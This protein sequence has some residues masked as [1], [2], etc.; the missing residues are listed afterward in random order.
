M[1]R[2]LRQVQRAIDRIESALFEDIALADLAAGVGASPWHF[3]RVFAAMTGMSPA[4]YARRRRL[5]ELCRRLSETEQP[6]VQIALEGGF[7]SQT[8]FTRAFSR[9]VGLSPAR[10]RNALREEPKDKPRIDRATLALAH[11]FPRIDAVALTA[12]N[13]HDVMEPKI[14]HRPA[15]HVVGLTGQY[16]P[17]TSTRIPE[18]WSRF[19][20]RLGEIGKRVDGRSYGVC[21]ENTSGDAEEGCFTYVVGVEV[22]QIERVP[23][24]MI[25]LTVPAHTYAVFTHRGHVSG[26]SDTFKRA[27]GQWLPA[28]QF[29]HAAAPD[30]EQYDERFNPT[31]ASGEIDLYLPVVKE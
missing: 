10:Y 28:T 16:S 27:L 13:E 15:F 8:A 9:Q 25:A 12:R 2:T 4:A 3:Q 21:M 6:L 30:F 14:E 23:E 17:A 5:A 29:Q 22:S 11:R 7:E 19:A 26:I 20:P 18:I 24:G 31:T 1:N